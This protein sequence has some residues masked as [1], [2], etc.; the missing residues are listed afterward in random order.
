M[1]LLGAV[2]ETSRSPGTVVDGKRFLRVRVTSERGK[3]VNINVPLGLLKIAS[4]LAGVGMAFIPKEARQEM[5]EQGINL[6]DIDFV[7]LVEQID[8]GLTDGELIDVETED[9]KEGLTNIKV[10]ID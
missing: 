3:K 6:A 4:K 1:G 2:E 9:D 10:Y 8:Q 5:E 7:E